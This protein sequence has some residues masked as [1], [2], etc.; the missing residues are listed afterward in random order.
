[1]KNF[2][3]HFLDSIEKLLHRKSFFHRNFLNRP[4]SAKLIAFGNLKEP[5]L[6]H[7]LCITYWGIIKRQ[8]YGK[9]IFSLPS[10]QR[11][12][13]NFLV[14]KTFQRKA[15]K[16]KKFKKVCQAMFSRFPAQI[17]CEN[18]TAVTPTG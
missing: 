14:S 4:C 17:C 16:T 3:Q 12:L 11:N 10:V 18:T 2:S 13:V 15:K 5:T 8:A 9:E 1:M 6:D 7:R